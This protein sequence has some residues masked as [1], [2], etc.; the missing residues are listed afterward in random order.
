MS[1]WDQANKGEKLG[2]VWR[3]RKKINKIINYNRYLPF[4][5]LIILWHTVSR[6]IC[7]SLKF[8]LHVSLKVALEKFTDTSARNSRV[9]ASKVARLTLE[10]KFPFSQRV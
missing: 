6:L 4:F 2:L 1:S 9:S 5:L 7:R 3:S 10:K 8:L